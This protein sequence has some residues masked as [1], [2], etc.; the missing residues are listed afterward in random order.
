MTKIGKL[1]SQFRKIC[2]GFYYAKLRFSNPKKSKVALLDEG[3]M[4]R[5]LRELVLYNLSFE[6]IDCR[7]DHWHKGSFHL[8]PHVVALAF[9]FY[10]QHL[11]KEPVSK[12]KET[13]ST[14]R[15]LLVAY[16][17][18]V[19]KMIGA[20]VVLRDCSGT[21][22]GSD[23]ERMS[24][25]LPD[26][27]FIAVIR[28]N[29]DVSRQ[30]FEK[31]KAEYFVLNERQRGDFIRAGHAPERIHVVG[32]INCSYFFSK[33]P[34]SEFKIEYDICLVSQIMDIFFGPRIDDHFHR[35]PHVEIHELLVRHLSRFAKERDL[36]VAVA[37]RPQESISNGVSPERDFFSR[38]LECNYEFI[39]NS[40]KHFSTYKTILKSRVTLTHFSSIAFEMMSKSTR[41]MF[42]Q[43]KHFPY[44]PLPEE[45]I[46][47]V[48]VP[49]YEVFESTLEKLMSLSESEYW[50]SSQRS[51]EALNGYDP[52]Q[53]AHLV[54]RK[55][56]DQA[57]DQ[58]VDN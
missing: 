54:I 1:I 27:K 47:K 48:T 22:G 35:R 25:C 36:K 14:A 3:E 34:Q 55:S 45:I 52:D 31:S 28:A 8:T 19:I 56:I 53:P 42:F 46:W 44:F 49:D 38:L 37:L 6:T 50:E 57:L 13:I 43:P 29:Y 39:D 21:C 23:F 51:V 4:T 7:F 18:A 15:A 10:W 58:K 2:K 5:M 20:K 17:C 16:F 26:A 9:R 30:F 32:S 40:V 24:H 11:R 33:H 41:V 12:S